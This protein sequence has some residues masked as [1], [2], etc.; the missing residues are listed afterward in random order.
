MADHYLKSVELLQEIDDARDELRMLLRTPK[1]VNGPHGPIRP[2]PVQ[3]Q[4]DGVRNTIRELL[5]LA[6][7]HATLSVRQ[8]LVGI[9]GQIDHHGLEA[10]L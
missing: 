1:S 4:I 7:I 5:K 2:A 9:A 8:E 6:D 10:V 3:S